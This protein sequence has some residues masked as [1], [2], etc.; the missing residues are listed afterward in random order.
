MAARRRS[1]WIGAIALAVA[2]LFMAVGTAAAVD[3]ATVTGTVFNN[4][5]RVAHTTS[6]VHIPYVIGAVLIGLATLATGTLSVWVFRGRKPLPVGLVIALVAMLC[7]VSG[8]ILMA[9]PAP[10]S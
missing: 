9:G 2:A 7:L 6:S 8:V 1:T 5:T 10:T 4:V 3:A